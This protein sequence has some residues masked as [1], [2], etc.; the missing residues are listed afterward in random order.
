MMEEGLSLTG[1]A[2]PS[3]PSRISKFTHPLTRLSSSL[4]LRAS[5]PSPISI[6]REPS[7]RSGQYSP[8]R[9]SPLRSFSFP[10]LPKGQ[11][12]LTVQEEPNGTATSFVPS[13]PRLPDGSFMSNGS[14]S[15]LQS[16]S[17]NS[18]HIN[19]SSLAPRQAISRTLSGNYHGQSG[20]YHDEE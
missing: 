7:L 14:V 16:R 6:S 13:S 4:G 11:I 18:S 19:L 1:G 5:R 12:N 9:V 17:R 10:P 3:S 2:P 8:A 15:S 20:S